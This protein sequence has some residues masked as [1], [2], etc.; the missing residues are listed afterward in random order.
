[1][2]NM[3]RREDDA[4]NHSKWELLLDLQIHRAELSMQNLELREAQQLLEESR[5]HYADLYDF[6]PVGYFTLDKIGH[7]QALNMTGACLLEKDRAFL[8]GKPFTVCFPHISLH[9]FSLYLQGI[10]SHLGPTT[11]DLKVENA[12]TGIRFFHLESKMD[13][14]NKM[15]RMIMS[16]ITQLKKTI[17]NNRKLLSENRRLMK[18]LFRVQEKERRTLAY[19]LHDELGQWLTAIR[20]E[21]EVILN[22]SKKDSII[23]TSAQAIKDCTQD[24]HAVIRN[25]LHQLRPALLDELGLP[26]A[27]LELKKQWCGY[28]STITL[29]LKMQ[30]E[31]TMFSEPL[32]IAVFRLIQESLNNIC[33]H[34][35]ATWAQISLAHKTI[36]PVE[37]LQLNIE[38]NGKGY[39]INQQSIGLGLL[40]M[41]ERVIAM[42][43]TLSV[44]S[45]PN[46]GTEIN[47]RLPINYSNNEKTNLHPAD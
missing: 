11:L 1:M 23:T 39:D 25:I 24:M 33:N 32:N 30:G 41:R 15:C 36:A 27:L 20:A 4:I 31:L 8:I 35:E 10:F 12:R 19:E 3:K 13:N 7:I 2:D 46:E 18:E 16:D 22:F 34:A 17:E 42:N 37:Y 21:T 14:D 43:G 45:A 26:N 9:A 5:N 6:A 40:S 29:E 28:H 38:D 44:R 47:I